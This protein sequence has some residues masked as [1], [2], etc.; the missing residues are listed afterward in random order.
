MMVVVMV[1]IATQRACYRNFQWLSAHDA[2]AMVCVI[3]PCER[4]I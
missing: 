4:H 3:L 1:V 2:V